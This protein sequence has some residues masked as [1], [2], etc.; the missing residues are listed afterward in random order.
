MIAEL[1][2]SEILNASIWITDRRSWK[3]APEDPEVG[4][5]IFYKSELPELAKLS[6]ERLQT[7]YNIKKIFGGGIVRRVTGEK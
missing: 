3:P 7:V 1:I 6:R 5:P 4:A 2:R